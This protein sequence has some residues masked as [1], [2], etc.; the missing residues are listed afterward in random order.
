MTFN[1][2]IHHRHSIRLKGY[3]YSQKGAYFVTICTQNRLC[4]FGNV[5]TGQMIIN[6]FGEI[7][8]GVWNKL[9]L[10]YSNVQLR[11]FAIMPNHVH[12]II[13]LT[14]SVGAGFKPAQ[15]AQYENTNIAQ[16]AKNRAG[17]K[18]APTK[19]YALSEIVRSLKTFSARR[20]NEMRLSSGI[21]IWQ[22]NYY[23]HIVRNEDEYAR[24]ADYINNN[25]YYWKQDKLYEEEPPN[26]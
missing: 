12:G 4:L 3:D 22:R 23:E 25:A 5:N 14:E 9:P 13:V 18:P 26:E 2:D 7:V 17:L 19:S 24:I 11:E 6:E 15:N 8:A 1:S 21:P 10:H 16:N 20:I